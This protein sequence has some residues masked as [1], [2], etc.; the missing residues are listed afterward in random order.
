METRN[1]ADINLSAML[2]SLL[3]ML[4]FKRSDSIDKQVE[5]LSNLT[6]GERKSIIDAYTGEDFSDLPAERLAQEALRLWRAGQRQQASKLYDHAIDRAP[7][8]ATLLLNRGNLRFEL[9]DVQGAMADYER[10]RQ[11]FPKLPDDL[12]TVQR[13]VQ[14]LGADSAVLK[15]L[16]EKRR[17]ERPAD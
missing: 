15:R 7:T 5:R 16:F 14:T 4:G 17:N 12:F 6:K 1:L 2:N 10:A 8:D 11:G 13:T 3:N 9:E